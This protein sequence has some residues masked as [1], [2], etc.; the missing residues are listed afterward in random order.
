MIITEVYTGEPKNIGDVLIYN[1]YMPYTGTNPLIGPNQEDWGVRFQ[2][3]MQIYNKKTNENLKAKIG[4]KLPEGAKCTIGDVIWINSIKSYIGEADFQ[5]ILALQ[6]D[7]I[8]HR[9][10][11][12]TICIHHMGGTVNCIGIVSLTPGKRFDIL[13]AQSPIPAIIQVLAQLQDF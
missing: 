3:V 2:D 12:E 13:K 5:T 9:G 7:G 10:I 11:M 4:E 1:N 6:L 8:S